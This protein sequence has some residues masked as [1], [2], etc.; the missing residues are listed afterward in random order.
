MRHQQAAGCGGDKASFHVGSPARASCQITLFPVRYQMFT[1]GH[2]RRLVSATH[3]R[4]APISR[5]F[6]HPSACLKG[7]NGRPAGRYAPNFCT[8]NRLELLTRNLVQNS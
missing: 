5:H 3:F 7:A 8:A 1:L 6:Q 2:S 4:F